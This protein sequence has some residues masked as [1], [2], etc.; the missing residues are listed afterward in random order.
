MCVCAVIRSTLWISIEYVEL[1]IGGKFLNEC[2]LST[3]GLEISLPFQS[4]VIYMFSFQFFP[5]DFEP[6]A[7]AHAW[8]WTS[9]YIWVCAVCCQSV[10]FSSFF[11]CFGRSFLSRNIE[12]LKRKS[13]ESHSRYCWKE[14]KRFFDL[15][16]NIILECILHEFLML[17]IH[18][19]CSLPWIYRIKISAS[20]LFIH[21]A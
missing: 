20:N 14:I 21:L 3:V 7:S 17:L 12:T 9:A 18:F 11:V 2:G 15:L 5:F 16:K 8:M 10:C 6:C 1:K 19:V 13:I 4:H